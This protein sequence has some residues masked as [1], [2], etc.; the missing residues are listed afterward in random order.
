MKA[1]G[2]VMFCPDEWMNDFKLGNVRESGIDAMW[3]G[4]KAGKFRKELYRSKLFPAC[5]RCCAING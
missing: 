5:A 3:N 2:D 4:E 1:N